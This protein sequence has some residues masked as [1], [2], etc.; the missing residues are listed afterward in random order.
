MMTT[1]IPHGWRKSS[2][3]NNGGASCVELNFAGDRVFLRD[4]KYLRDPAN[5]PNSQPLLSMEAALWP[6]FCADVVRSVQ[7]RIHG[8]P[9]I[10]RRSDGWVTVR[11]EGS[12]GV[13]LTFTPD[14]WTAFIDGIEAGEFELAAA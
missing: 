4:S 13:V 2:F 6:V 8:L 9:V 10:D 14:E 1:P 11:A 7:R 3:S 5:D 12:D